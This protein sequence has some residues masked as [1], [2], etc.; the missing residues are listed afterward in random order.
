[1]GEKKGEEAAENKNVFMPVFRRFLCKFSISGQE[2]LKCDEGDQLTE[3]KRN[4][5]NRK[6]T[7]RDSKSIWL[8]VKCL[9]ESGDQKRDKHID[10]VLS[11]FFFFFFFLGSANILVTQ[12]SDFF[13]AC[14]CCCQ[15][16]TLN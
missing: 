7:K 4:K 11:L 9:M 15:Q 1:M 2:K 10:C 8:F 12:F 5:T 6:R 14:L 16:E 13:A 3:Q